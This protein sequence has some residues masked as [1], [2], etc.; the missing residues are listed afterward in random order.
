MGGFGSGN[1]YH[2]WRGTKKTT[3]E[4]SLRIDANRWMREGILRAGVHLLG[5]RQWTYSSGSTFRVDCEVQTMDMGRPLLRLFYSWT[6]NGDSQPQSEDYHVAL[7]ATRPRFGG[8]RWWFVCPLVVKGVACG[9]RVGKLYLPP[10]GRYFG[11]RTCHDLTYTSC[12]E[13]HK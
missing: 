6:W 11:C 2:W 5:S 13:S 7:T 8:L 9:R 4:D 10:S 12:Q 1:R 3:V